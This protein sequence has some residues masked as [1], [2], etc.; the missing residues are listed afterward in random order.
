MSLDEVWT[1][2][3]L[4]GVWTMGLWATLFYLL[5]SHTLNLSLGKKEKLYFKKTI[6]KSVGLPV[7]L[8]RGAF[9]IWA[10]LF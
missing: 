4:G 1:E 2:F 8:N 10:G 5:S 6:V 3:T 7:L 9:Y